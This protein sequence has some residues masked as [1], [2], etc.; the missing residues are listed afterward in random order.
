VK[1]ISRFTLFIFAVILIYGSGLNHYEQIGS[2]IHG[3]QN[4]HYK[5]SESKPQLNAVQIQGQ[6]FIELVNTFSIHNL[7]IL[8]KFDYDNN[9]TPKFK[10][11][12]SLKYF[13]LKTLRLISNLFTRKLIFPYHFFW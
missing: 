5:Y 2:E 12:S 10:L 4:Y 9:A 7:K 13:N 6:N 8:S 3:N 1:Y 11:L